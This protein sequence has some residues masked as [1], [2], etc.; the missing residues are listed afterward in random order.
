MTS[1][2]HQTNA[3]T[4]TTPQQARLGYRSAVASAIIAA[5]FCVAVCIFLA[6]GYLQRIA[7]D[8]LASEQYAAMKLQLFEPPAEDS[9]GNIMP[10]E[11]E[12]ALMRK[13]RDALKAEIQAMDLRLRRQYFYQLHFAHVGGLLL[14]AGFVVFLISAKTAAELR[15][16]VPMPEPQAT[17]HDP[18]PQAQS[19]ARRSIAGLGVLL[20]VST[21]AI[22]ALLPAVRSAVRSA[23]EPDGQL[24]ANDLSTYPTP[25]ELKQNWPRFRGP[26]GL[27][28]SAY[29]NLPTTWDVASGKSIVW[30]TPVPL[31]GN[32]SPVVWGDRV[33]LTGATASRREI[34]C[35]DTNFGKTVWTHHA[36]G[37][38]ASNAKPPEILEDTGFA[39]PSIATDG[40]RLVAW[41]A[42]GD[43]VCL[44]LA[45]KELWARSLGIPEN[46]YGHATSPI[47]YKNLVLLKFDQAS[48]GD[49]KSKV[50][51]LDSTS[52]KTIWEKPRKVPNSWS[53][54]ILISHAGRDQLITT[55]D[56]WVVAYAPSDGAELWRVECLFGDHGI[57]PVF[58]A[59]LVQTGN[60]YCDWSAI[61]PDGS[62]NVTETHVAW[63]AE[64]GLPDTVSPL[65]NDEFLILMT[66][67]GAIT[68]YDVKTGEML[69]EEDLG[70]QITSSPSFVG[71]NVFIFSKTDDGKCWVIEPTRDACR[72][73]S[74]SS[75]AEP[76]VTSPALQDGRF[77]IRG[78]KNLF[79]IGNKK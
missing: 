45:G 52:G 68:C 20:V 64:D 3:V 5:L 49:G 36:K 18:E 67:Y 26:G 42:N 14:L 37:T 39:A 16:W 46:S 69:W 25:E 71:K 47:I 50:L 78:Q 2:Q 12:M 7:N 53:T 31:P 27:G 62:G 74:E 54:P 73:I 15:G 32:N 34:Y 17:P 72:R 21:L 10:S 35:F 30:K 11:E 13:K 65:A 56:P 4:T 28:I 79:C 51:A 57:S 76:C 9:A 48:A 58:A 23:L 44:N 40:R 43:V 22:A 8:P 77:Y 38:P 61:K 6:I 75:L 19:T 24:A 59:G 1:T 66:A 41:F 60:E 29:D 55:A 33:F 70:E 63:T